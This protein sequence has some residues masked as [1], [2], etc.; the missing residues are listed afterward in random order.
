ME[1]ELNIWAN[2]CNL[3][4]LNLGAISKPMYVLCVKIA[5]SICT[6]IES[7][8]RRSDTM[9][10]GGDLLFVD[11]TRRCEGYRLTESHPDTG[12]YTASCRAEI[13]VHSRRSRQET[14]P[15][16]GGNTQRLFCLA[17]KMKHYVD[18]K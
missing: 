9:S 1:S 7:V 6:A 18:D 17:K 10:T 5:K 14:F 16:Q 2:V 15:R 12:I 11:G 13:V 8:S 4:E 3:E